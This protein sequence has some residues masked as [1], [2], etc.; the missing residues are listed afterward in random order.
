MGKGS[1]GSRVLEGAQAASGA[2]L[3]M[4]GVH[5]TLLFLL[6]TFSAPLLN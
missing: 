6:I 3:T 1:G 4:Q 2:G 5:S